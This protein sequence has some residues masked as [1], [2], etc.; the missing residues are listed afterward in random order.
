MGG[1]GLGWDCDAVAARQ[2]HVRC[3][4]AAA[5]ASVGSGWLINMPMTGPPSVPAS[6]P[7]PGAR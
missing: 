4:D 7:C 2:A 5:Y 6:P 1:E 3:S